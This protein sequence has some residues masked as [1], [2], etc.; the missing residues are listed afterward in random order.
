MSDYF[1]SKQDKLDFKQICLGHYKRILE[2]TTTEF[3]G[4]YW[5]YIQSANTTNKTYITDKRKEFVQAVESL[6]NALFP[7]FDNK[8]KEDYDSFLEE[9]KKINEEY[10]DEEGFV[11]SNVEEEN[12]IKHSIKKLELM[13]ELFRNLSCLMYRLDYFK[14]ASY[15]EGD[16]DLIDIDGG[17]KQ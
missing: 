16:D 8:M 15:H 6:G 4:G 13:K 17:E 1:T 14:G 9:E 7:H 3:T 11:R 2:I 10:S 12:K 5:N